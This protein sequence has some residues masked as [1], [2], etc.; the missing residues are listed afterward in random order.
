MG[1]WDTANLEKPSLGLESH[2]IS[3]G[4]NRLPYT[5][6]AVQAFSFLSCF[7]LVVLLVWLI[8]YLVLGWGKQEQEYKAKEPP[9]PKVSMVAL[10]EENGSE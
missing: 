5:G 4:K 7:S 1:A 2:L 8:L 10:K 9:G 3:H 6:F